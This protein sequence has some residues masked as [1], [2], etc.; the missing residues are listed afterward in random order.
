MVRRTKEGK[1]TPLTEYRRR[2]AKIDPEWHQKQ[3]DQRKDYYKKTKPKQQLQKKLKVKEQRSLVIKQMGGKCDSCREE[4]NPHLKHSNIHFHH[5]AYINSKI[6]KVETYRQVLDIINRGDDP[7]I[8]FGLL[9]YTCHMILTHLQKNREK[10]K[11]ALAY[12]KKI[13]VV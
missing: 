1:V 6:T 3:K 2:R 13:D 11:K 4:Y 8:Q 5:K 7:K 12:A 10:S 9:C